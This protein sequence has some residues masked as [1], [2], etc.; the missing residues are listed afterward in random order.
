MSLKIQNYMANKNRH[1]SEGTGMSILSNPDYFIPRENEK[2]VTVI[3][4]GK[5]FKKLLNEE[6]H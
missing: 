4:K 3:D 2:F 1:K 6:S 5:S